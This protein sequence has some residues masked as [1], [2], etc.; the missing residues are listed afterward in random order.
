MASS[1]EVYSPDKRFS[2]VRGTGAEDVHGITMDD[3]RGKPNF[4]SDTAAQE[5]YAEF[6]KDADALVGPQHP[7]V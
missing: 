1:L 6:I 2:D 7:S 4:R 5:R 3:V